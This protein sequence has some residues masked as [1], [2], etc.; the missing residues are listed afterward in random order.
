MGGGTERGQKGEA[1][2][3]NENENCNYGP[4]GG[5]AGKLPRPKENV[6]WTSFRR[7]TDSPS[8]S[9]WMTNLWEE[10]VL[11]MCEMVLAKE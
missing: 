10:A 6:D 7:E 2:Q 1:S 5:A 3:A 8:A 9:R 4:Y 11:F